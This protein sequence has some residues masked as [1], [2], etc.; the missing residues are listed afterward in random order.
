MFTV[1]E[2]IVPYKG[3]TFH[4]QTRY[5][6]SSKKH[7]M[8]KYHVVIKGIEQGP[9]TL[10]EL[11][12]KKIKKTTL[13]WA[14]GKENWIAAS[15]V[16]ELKA[17][18]KAT[19]PPIPVKNKKSNKVEVEISKKK[20]K[21]ITPKTEVV[22]AKETK[23]VFQQIVFGL[24]IGAV[25]FPI[26]YFGVYKANKYDNFNVYKEVSFNKFDN[27]MTGINISDFPFSWYGMDYSIVEHNIER[28]K[29]IYTEKSMYGAFITFLIASGVLLV[30]RYVSKGAKW[31]QETSQKEI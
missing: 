27:V 16:E 31:V 14:E 15:K 4:I 6:Q 23:S 11:G 18:I 28:R 8:T 3:A 12:D 1:A 29:E 20:E 13:V 2:K 17:L 19:P 26:F 24:I 5:Q 7:N 21:L 25:S 10:D 9:F 22:V 30:T